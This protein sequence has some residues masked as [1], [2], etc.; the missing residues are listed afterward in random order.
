MENVWDV[1]EIASLRFFRRL[2]RAHSSVWLERVPDK[3]EVH[4]SSPCAPTGKKSFG[5]ASELFFFALKSREGEK[6]LLSERVRR[7]FAARLGG[8][9]GVRPVGRFSKREKKGKIAQSGRFSKKKKDETDSGAPR[10]RRRDVRQTLRS[11]QK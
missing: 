5:I 10:D 8:S 3:D 9:V 11:I 4:G 6:T 1:R 7:T 2:G